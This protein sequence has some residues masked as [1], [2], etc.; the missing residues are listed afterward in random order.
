MRAHFNQHGF[1]LMVLSMRALIWVALNACSFISAWIHFH[2][3]I[4]ESTHLGRPECVLIFISM[5]SLSWYYQ[6]EHSFGSP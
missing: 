3:S 1:T 2:G 4:N 5:D 6:R